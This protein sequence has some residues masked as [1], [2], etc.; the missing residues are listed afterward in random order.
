MN[1]FLLFSTTSEIR[2]IN[3]DSPDHRDTVIPLTNVVSPL[4]L[5][6]DAVEDMVYWTDTTTDTINRANVDGSR[7][8]V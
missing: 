1:T 7:E 5:D 2:R 6:F 8:Q 4:G 3:M